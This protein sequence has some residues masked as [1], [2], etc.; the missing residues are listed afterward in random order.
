MIDDIY[1]VNGT[2]DEH[3]ELELFTDAVERL[4][5]KCSG[6]YSALL[7]SRR[8]LIDFFLF[9][10]CFRWDIKAMKQLPDYMKICFLVLYNTVNEMAYDI[11]K[12]QG[13]DVV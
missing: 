13:H 7:L 6:I 3:H 12:E 5:G 4:V 1:G 8:G 9:C 11:L 10:T 2:L